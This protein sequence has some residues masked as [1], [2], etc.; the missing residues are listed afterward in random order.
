MQ[1]LDDIQLAKRA[2]NGDAQ[3]F[4][5]LLKRHYRTVFKMAYKWTGNTADAE[6]VAQETC[7]KLAGS[8]AQFQGQS[9]FTTWLYRVV[10]NTAKDY[11]TSRNRQTVRDNAFAD[12]Q[13][14]ESSATTHEDSIASAELYRAIHQLPEGQRDAVLLVL[15]EGLSHKEAGDILGC[16]EG[17]ISWR[18]SEARKTLLT[19]LQGGN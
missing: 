13:S 11:H 9:T 16:A 5:L 8:I 12:A 15:A 2:G 18:V 14:L 6:D 7:V 17:T 1:E 4:A 10:V 19:F 3:A